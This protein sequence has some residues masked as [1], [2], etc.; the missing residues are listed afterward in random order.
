MTEDYYNSTYFKN[1]GNFSNARHNYPIL[2]SDRKNPEVEISGTVRGFDLPGLTITLDTTASSVNDFYNG[3]NLEVK[4]GTNYYNRFILDYDGAT[5]KATIEQVL[6]NN[7]TVGTDTYKIIGVPHYRGIVQEVD[8]TAKT[9]T[10]Q[11]YSTQVDFYN[12]FDI[13]IGN[14]RK[15]ITDY[16][17]TMEK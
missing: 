3:Y 2:L 9:I 7:P 13:I 16:D 5:K 15:N 8:T 1:W 17:Q 12:H 10:L 6:P 14:E 11:T 4:V